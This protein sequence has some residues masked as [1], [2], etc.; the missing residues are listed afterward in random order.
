M[1]G[2]DEQE[3]GVQGFGAQR[4]NPLAELLMRQGSSNRPVQH[5]SEALANAASMIGGAYLGRLDN[6]RSNA[7]TA[8]AESKF[9]K[10]FG[11]VPHLLGT[12]GRAPSPSPPP[13][14]R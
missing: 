6:D 11:L 13:G 14:H 12:A 9:E 4:R 2:L 10:S 8:S 3:V 5:W 7:A 1:W